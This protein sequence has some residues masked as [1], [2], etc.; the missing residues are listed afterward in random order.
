MKV[1][2]LVGDGIGKEITES[3]KEIFKSAGADIQWEELTAGI[4]VVDE[5]GTPMP[6]HVI[7]SIKRN[8]IALKAPL[9]TPIGGGFRSVNVELRKRLKLYANVRPVISLDGVDSPL[10]DGTN[11]DMVIVRENTEG[12]YSG[13]EHYIGDP[14]NPTA[15]ETIK[16]ITKEASEKISEFA[17]NLA[18]KREKKNVT[19]SHKANIQK[20]TDG[21]FLKT[22]REVSSKYPTVS[23]D[24]LI[25]DNM[26]MQLVNRPK[27]FDVIVA[28][29]FYGDILS[30]LCASFVGGLGVAAGANIGEE[31]AVFEAVH[32]TAPDIA[33]QN[34][35]N[36]TALLLSAIMMLRHIGQEEVAN[37]IENSLKKTLSEGKSLTGDLGG[38]SGTTDFTQAIIE[39]L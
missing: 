33:G 16:V 28:P 34:K 27:T 21:L 11:I 15:A 2:L 9:G 26:M 20:F 13:I 6:D 19:I 29:N 37:K 7:E 30:D 8:K 4:D 10:K 3:V 17:F 35:A 23:H 32:G 14:D 22:A 36:P 18:S 1:T 31:Y 5:Y 38:T 24:D 12:L 25:I 39:N